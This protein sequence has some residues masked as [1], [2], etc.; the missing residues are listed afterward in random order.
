MEKK[1]ITIKIKADLIP[2]FMTYIKDVGKID[3]AIARIKVSDLK[4]F[5]AEANPRSFHEGTTTKKIETTI[6]EE[7]ELFEVL[8][9]GLTI[10]CSD[11]IYDKGEVTFVFSDK[12]QGLVDGGHSFNV[13]MRHR[14]A[15]ANIIAKVIYGDGAAALA[16]RI[17]ETFNTTEKVKEMSLNN[18]RGYFDFIKK[19][20][21]NEPYYF[22]IKWEENSRKRIPCTRIIGLLNSFDPDRWGHG[23]ISEKA[24]TDS[25]NSAR[26][27][28]LEY[29]K[30]YEKYGETIENPYFSLKNV[31]TDIIELFDY[32]ENN[33][34]RLYNRVG[35]YKTLSVTLPDKSKVKLNDIDKGKKLR[36]VFSE[37]T[38]PGY[39][40]TPIIYAIIAPMRI[41]LE[42]DKDGFWYFIADPKQIIEAIGP[43]LIKYALDYYQ[44]WN[45]SAAMK[46]P[47]FWIYLYDKTILLKN[48]IQ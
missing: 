48:K 26:H 25:Y 28:Q 17:S 39:V 6:S 45:P 7:P 18:L 47:K 38:L 2:T 31:V 46:D 42:R 37:N 21:I 3:T 40:P 14:D 43:Q 33:F 23:G 12:N 30:M 11:L 4:Y 5:P 9:R 34:V 24:P 41:F 44:I 29:A 32:V 36:T 35:R 15:N 22:D 8:N 19:E 27:T 10:I 16:N 13:A 20:M 1:I